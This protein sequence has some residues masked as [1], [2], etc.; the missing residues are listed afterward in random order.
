MLANNLSLPRLL[1]LDVENLASVQKSNMKIYIG[2]CVYQCFFYVYLETDLKGLRL[3]LS[4][5]LHTYSR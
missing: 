4:L 5:G 1:P 2:F 3:G